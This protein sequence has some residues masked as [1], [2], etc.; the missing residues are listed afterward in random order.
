M[1]KHDRVQKM[2]RQFTDAFDTLRLY[3]IDR[4]CGK[5]LTK[6][7]LAIRMPQIAREH[8]SRDFN[9]FQRDWFRLDGYIESLYT[10]YA[11]KLGDN[12]YAVVQAATKL[13]SHLIEN[14][15]LRNDKHSLQWLAGEWPI[16][17]KKECVKEAFDITGYLARESHTHEALA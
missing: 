17:F 3:I 6:A 1:V 4:Q 5:E 7:A 14:L 10:K 8:E 12:A 11:D 2:Q 9:A 13:V 15:R 16:E